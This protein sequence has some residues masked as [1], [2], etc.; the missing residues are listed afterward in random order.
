MSFI[1]LVFLLILW[2]YFWQC[3]PHY[4]IDYLDLSTELAEENSHFK[5]K[6]VYEPA[7]CA[8]KNLKI[9]GVSVHLDEFPEESRTVSQVPDFSHSPPPSLISGSCSPLL[10][11]PSNPLGRLSLSADQIS[12]PSLSGSLLPQI[13]IVT[14]AGHSEIKLKLKQNV[15]VPGPKVSVWWWKMNFTLHLCQLLKLMHCTLHCTI[16]YE[17][18]VHSNELRSRHCTISVWWLDFKFL[19]N[20]S[21]CQM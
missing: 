16:E 15:T 14:F 8:C 18:D 20:T 1:L 12:K 3:Q 5:A 10:H 6:S 13:K 21:Y 4:R 17:S 9:F 19:C 2:F 11:N 7:A